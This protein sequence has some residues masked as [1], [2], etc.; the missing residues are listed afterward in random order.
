MRA[1]RWR[2]VLLLFTVFFLQAARADQVMLANGDRLTGKVISKADDTLTFETEYAGKIKIRW[3]DVVSVMTDQPVT[4]M[5]A[6]GKLQKGRLERTASGSLELVSDDGSRAVRLADLSHIN[7]PPHVA[8]TG[9]TYKGRVTLLASASTGNTEDARLY[10]EAELRARAKQYSYG[11]EF[12]GEQKEESGE[13]TAQNYW[14]GGRYNRV[15]DEERFAYVRSS[16]SHDE[17]TD[18]Q[19][20]GTIGAGLGWNLFDTEKTH[21]SVLGGLEYVATDRSTGVSQQYPAFGW[22]IDYRQWVWGDRLELFF[23]QFGFTTLVSRGDTSFKTRGGVRIPLGSNLTANA[24]V[25]YDYESNPGPGR[26]KTDVQL[27]LGLG[28]DF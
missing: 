26:E 21:L 19:L 11:I 8:G 16:L 20:R 15:I 4:V 3:S 17:F 28:Y 7:P 18:I 25:N 1:H 12:R 6:D 13:T 14:L 9:V 27:L 10:G 5:S 22:G 23:N 24:Q 2:A